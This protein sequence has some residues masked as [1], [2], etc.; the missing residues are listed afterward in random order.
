MSSSRDVSKD[1]TKIQKNLEK[2]VTR[3][4]VSMV[5]TFCFDCIF[6]LRLIS[7]LI[8]ETVVFFDNIYRVMVMPKIF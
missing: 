1:V 4:E 3:P 6:S 8:T 5:G 7:L 2:I